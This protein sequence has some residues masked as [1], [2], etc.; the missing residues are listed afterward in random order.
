MNLPALKDELFTF[1]TNT[2]NLT[3]TEKQKLRDRCVTLYPQEYLRY[4]A[5]N[6][7][8]DNATNRGKFFVEKTIGNSPNGIFGCWSEIWLNGSRVE[9]TAANPVETF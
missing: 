7:L 6:Q 2:S 3:A 9:I 4:R 8:A 5:E 1:L